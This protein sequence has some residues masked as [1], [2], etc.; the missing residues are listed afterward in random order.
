[1]DELSDDEGDCVVKKEVMGAWNRR[2]LIVEAMLWEWIG[3]ELEAAQ[4]F[5]F[6]G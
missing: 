2:R 3:L 5:L 4:V 1:M 6:G